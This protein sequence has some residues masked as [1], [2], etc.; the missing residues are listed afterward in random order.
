MQISILKHQSC[1]LPVDFSRYSYYVEI[2]LLSEIITVHFIN[3][4]YQVNPEVVS[5]CRVSIENTVEL[6]Q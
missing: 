2:Q 3:H 6:F 5:V 4:R 1:R